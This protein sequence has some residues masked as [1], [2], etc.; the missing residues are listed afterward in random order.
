MNKSMKIKNETTSEIVADEVI[1]NNGKA[2]SGKAL[3]D[4]CVNTYIEVCQLH[5]TIILGEND[6]DN[7]SDAIGFYQDKIK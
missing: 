6:F 7:I 2:L 1:K 5:S 4:C 3:E